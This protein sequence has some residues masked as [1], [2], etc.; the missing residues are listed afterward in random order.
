M[1]KSIQDLIDGVLHEMEIN[2]LNQSTITQY[3]RGFYRPIIRYFT[4]KNNGYYSLEILESCKNNYEKTF[5]YC[6]NYK[7]TR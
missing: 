3:R 2:G 7:C 1:H 4:E 5:V 6:I